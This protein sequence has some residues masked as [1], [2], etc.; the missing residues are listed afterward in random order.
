[1]DSEIWE[2]KMSD[3]SNLERLIDGATV[4][5]TQK[6]LRD[7]AAHFSEKTEFVAIPNGVY[8]WDTQV[9]DVTPDGI[10][11]HVES[12][13]LVPFFGMM[14]GY[15]SKRDVMATWKPK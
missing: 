8:S 4:E 7:L 9:Y 14:V 2:N 6:L 13:P 12:T 1:M 10:K 11:M 5:S 15:N 3:D